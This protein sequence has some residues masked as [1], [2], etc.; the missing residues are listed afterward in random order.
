[1]SITWYD[2][3]DES[4]EETSNKVMDFTGKYESG[5]ESSDE[6]ITDEELT[7]TYKLLYSQWKEACM[8]GEKQKKIVSALLM[9]KEKLVST[10]TGLGKEVTLLNSKLENM[11]KFV[12]MLSNNS[13]MLDDTL[14]VM[15]MS[16][17]KI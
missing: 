5:S 12:H 13:N 17:N 16:R 3:D 2:S 1:M 6:E 15:K 14:K 9:E 11:T 4:E 8:V 7:D 10:I